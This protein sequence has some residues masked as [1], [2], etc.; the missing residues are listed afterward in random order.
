MVM[1]NQSE[2]IFD[3]AN[4]QTKLDQNTGLALADPF[5][6]SGCVKLP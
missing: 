5:G 2:L 6:V 3:N 1:E 4:I